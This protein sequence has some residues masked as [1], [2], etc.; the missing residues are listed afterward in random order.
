MKEP[1]PPVATTLGFTDMAWDD[2]VD[3]VV[4]L[5][6]P[7]AAWGPQQVDAAYAVATEAGACKGGKLGPEA[8]VALTAALQERASKGRA[9]YP[10][11]A[12][13]A[14]ARLVWGLLS[15]VPGVHRAQVAGSVR[16]R[17]PWCHDGDLVVLTDKGPSAAAAVSAKL[18]QHAVGGVMQKDGP[19]YKRFDLQI[20]FFKGPIQGPIEFPVDVYLTD[21]PNHWSTLM[22]IRTG[23]R[24]HNVQLTRRAQA[25]RWT[26]H[27]DGRGLVDQGE[28]VIAFESEEDIMRLLGCAHVEPASR[29][30]WSVHG[31]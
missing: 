2:F 17:V 9:V 13:E 23:S 19:K 31:Q 12:A 11:E 6:G 25:R 8:L 3:L 27:A 1:L 30:G 16:R 18:R 20:E 10:F 24:R 21:D 29:G 4:G 14:A 7:P 28:R 5:N 22:L 26:L 15:G